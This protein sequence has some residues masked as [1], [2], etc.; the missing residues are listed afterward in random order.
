MA[1]PAPPLYRLSR[2]LGRLATVAL[3]LVLLFVAA[4]AGSA[5][6]IRPSSSGFGTSERMVGPNEVGIDSSIALRNPG[7]FVIHA[8]TIRAAVSLPKPNLTLVA[9]G[10]S[11]SVDVPAGSNTSIPIALTIPLSGAV[12]RMLA[13]E[14]LSLPTRLWVN[15]SYAGLFPIALAL[16]LNYSWGAPLEGFTASSGSPVA[17]SNGTSQVP[18]TVGFRDDASFPVDGNVTIVVDGPSGS[19]CGTAEQIVAVSAGSSYAGSSDVSVLDSCL[20]GSGD[21]VEVSFGGP[22]W[23]FSIPP[24]ALP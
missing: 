13:T 21:T 18:V 15:A 2:A 12:G 5:A 22:D 11:P 16:S 20:G 7:W 9:A 14:D 6:Q 3:V 8:L 10:G 4:L 24:Q 23:S 19:A 1:R 17:G